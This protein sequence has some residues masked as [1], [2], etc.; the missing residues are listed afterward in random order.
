MREVFFKQEQNWKGELGEEEGETEISSRKKNSSWKKVEG[1][2][3]R[4][5]TNSVEKKTEHMWDPDASE[6]NSYE[7]KKARSK[8]HGDTEIVERRKSKRKPKL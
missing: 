8:R 4:S 2:K 3:R 7:T 6:T 5:S 1:R